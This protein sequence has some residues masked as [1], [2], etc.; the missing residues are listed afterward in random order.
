MTEKITHKRGDA[1]K[2]NVSLT[3]DDNITPINITGWTI[4]SQVRNALCW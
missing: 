1:F 4:R 2:I 3:E